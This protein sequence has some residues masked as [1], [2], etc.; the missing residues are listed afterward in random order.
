VLSK[1]HYVI[2][3]P[4]LIIFILQSIYWNVET[5]GHD[6]R[7]TL[8]II[9][10]PVLVGL[11][12]LAIYRRPFLQ[13]LFSAAT[14]LRHKLILVVFYLFQGLFV[15]YFTF[16]LV[17]NMAWKYFNERAASQNPS[18][19]FVCK[20]NEI[21]KAAGQKGKPY[22]IDFELNNR[23]ERLYVVRDFI[24][25]LDKETPSSYLLHLNVKE[26]LWHYYVLT[27]Y[28]LIKKPQ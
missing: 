20:V 14:R 4:F 25:E 13:N 21:K 7:H 2:P 1:K 8:F 11:M 9:I 23:N 26:G 18:E 6:F 12:S 5:I 19:L 27:D 15:S 28:D 10:L 17:A 16:G 3:V 24:K 22:Y